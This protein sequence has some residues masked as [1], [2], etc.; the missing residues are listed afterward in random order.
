MP[1]TTYETLYRCKWM[2]SGCKTTAQCVAVLRQQL[3]MFE[4]WQKN[5]VILDPNS[6]IEDDY[7][8]FITTDPD[9]AKKYEF[10]VRDSE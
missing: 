8:E 1:S 2:F 4:D 6:S 10:D 3:E 5:G 9:L 7:A